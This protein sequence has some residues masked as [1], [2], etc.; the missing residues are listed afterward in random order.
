MQDPL[1]EERLV[2]GLGRV[3]IPV[4]PSEV[5][6]AQL[7]SGL[8]QMA[9]QRYGHSDA[10]GARRAVLQQRVAR[11]ARPQPYAYW[12]LG[13]AAL[14]LMLAGGSI[15]AWVLRSRLSLPHL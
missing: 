7:R 9:Q 5:F 12:W 8:E 11:A 3:L 10:V 13:A 6:R 1:W 14:G 15:L 4:R 2:A